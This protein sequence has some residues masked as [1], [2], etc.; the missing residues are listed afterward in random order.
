MNG[1][2]PI[3]LQS[4]GLF[5]RLRGKKPPENAYAEIH[6]L[7]ARTSIREVPDD[8][9]DWILAEYE[10]TLADARPRLR[11]LYTTVLRY[12]AHDLE[13]TDAEVEQL[14]RLKRLLGLT[15]QDIREIEAEALGS[16]YRRELQTAMADGSVTPD[17]QARVFVCRT[18]WSRRS[19]SKRGRPRWRAC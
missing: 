10:L 18:S 13:L 1:L 14:R 2:Q 8:A 15:D 9:V 4:P 7:L 16:L 19:A 6:N 17:E 3:P 11:A 12:V 5:A